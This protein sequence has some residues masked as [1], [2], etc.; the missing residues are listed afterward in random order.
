MKQNPDLFSFLAQHTYNKLNDPAYCLDLFKSDFAKLKKPLEE[1]DPVVK[2]LYIN[3]IRLCNNTTDLD[4]LD[5]LVKL[6]LGKK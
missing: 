1:D 5:E 4:I 6:L 3:L 2:N